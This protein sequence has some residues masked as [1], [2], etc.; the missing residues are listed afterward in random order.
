MQRITRTVGLDND[1]AIA[2][3]FVGGDRCVPSSHSLSTGSGREPVP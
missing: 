2:L 1:R 3:R